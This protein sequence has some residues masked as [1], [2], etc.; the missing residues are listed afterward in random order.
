M[1][2]CGSNI[3]WMI[4][5]GII[6]L[7][8]SGIG[9]IHRQFQY[10]ESSCH[11]IKSRAYD[12]KCEGRNKVNCYQPIWTV[13]YDIPEV[14]AEPL[15]IEIR[16]NSLLS[17][18][19]A[20]NRVE[21]Y[22]VCSV[23]CYI[24]RL[25]CLQS[26]RLMV[27]YTCYRNGVKPEVLWKR[28]NRRA[29]IIGLTLGVLLVVFAFG[30]WLLYRIYWKRMRRRKHLASRTSPTDVGEADGQELENVTQTDD[31]PSNLPTSV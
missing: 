26:D 8:S 11:V 29:L 1:G 13:L 12:R 27:N 5:L 22:R 14:D 2:D 19:E 7:I 28:P 9:A 10:I 30:C 31:R 21:E 3:L 25:F 24:Q 17:L 4:L 15:R 6:V 16:S 18:T 20:L 23:F